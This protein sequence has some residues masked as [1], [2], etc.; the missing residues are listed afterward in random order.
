[1][2]WE[3]TKYKFNRILNKIESEVTGTFEQYPLKLAWAIT[4]HKSQGLTFDKIIIDFGRGTF[5]YGQA[6]VALSRVRTING[7]FLKR[8]IVTSDISVNEAV[9]EF[10]KSFNDDKA[11]KEYISGEPSD[12]QGINRDRGQTVMRSYQT[13]AQYIGSKNVAPGAQ[14]EKLVMMAEEDINEAVQRINK[15]YANQWKAYRQQVENT[16]LNLFK[17]YKPI[18]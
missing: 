3:N 10:A 6:Y 7:L 8:K 18:D 15:F 5:A 16:K 4:I 9:K 12:K 13:A 17:D 2:I 11:I 1:V 14:E